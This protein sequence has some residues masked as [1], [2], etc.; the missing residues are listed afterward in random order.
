VLD[1][2]EAR[3]ERLEALLA[4]VDVDVD[5]E[6]EGHISRSVPFDIVQTARDDGADLVLMGYPEEH[7]DVAEAV[8]YRSPVDVVFTSGFDGR[9]LESVTVGAGGGPHHVAM[10]PLA[11]AFGAAGAEVHLVSVDPAGEGT[12]ED[13]GTTVD[14][15]EHTASVTVETVAADSVA[16]GLVEAAAE[17]GGVLLIGASRDRRLRRWAFGSTPD[18][19]VEYAALEGVP[20]MVYASSLGVPERVE[21]RLFPVYRYLRRALSRPEGRPSPREGQQQ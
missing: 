8:E 4:D 10:L 12:P 1:D 11:D 9:A 17:H 19:V 2:A 7:P 13:A 16:G 3:T 15:M 6:V 20:V 14:A 21:D 5:Y 18:R